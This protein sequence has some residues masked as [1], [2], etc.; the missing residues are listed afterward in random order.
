MT[1]QKELICLDKIAKVDSTILPEFKA[2]A[3]DGLF[4][5]LISSECANYQDPQFS[6]SLKQKFTA[7]TFMQRLLYILA[8]LDRAGIVHGDLKLSNL[9]LTASDELVVTDFSGSAI[10]QRVAVNLLN[11]FKGVMVSA[12][13]VTCLTCDMHAPELLRDEMVQNVDMYSVGKIF[14]FV[15]DEG[16]WEYSTTTCT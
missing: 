13:Q 9:L 1:L 10:G 6:K 11:T 15:A 16:Y 12:D 4:W 5:V 14:Q 8:V 3:T 2:Y 7:D